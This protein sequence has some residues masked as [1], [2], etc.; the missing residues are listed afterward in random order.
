M[1]TN[2]TIKPE[3]HRGWLVCL[4]GGLAIFT[5][6]G[7]GM[8]I[9][10]TY[11]PY[12][13]QLNG[14]TNAQ[15]SLITTVRSFFAILA[16]LITSRLVQKIGLRATMGFGMGC[17]VLAYVVF[18]FA[19]SF[20]A[21]CV[22]GALSGLSYA[23][24][25]MV[26][27]SFAIARWFDVRR[28][29]ALGLAAAGSGVATIVAPTFVARSLQAQGLSATFFWEAAIMVV[30]MILVLA[31]VRNSP[32][33]LGLTPYGHGAVQSSTNHRAQRAPLSPTHWWLMLAVSFLAGAPVGAGFAHV[34]V[35]YSSQGF[36]SDQIT[37][38]FSYLGIVLMIGK[39][40]YGQISDV[41]GGY[42]SNYLIFGI[43]ILGM[44]LC[45]LSP[46]GSMAVA[47][48]A[49]TGVALSLSLS[50]I[51]QSIWMHELAPATQYESRVRL[52]NVAFMLGNLSF[53]ATPG[54]IADVT[55]SYIPAFALFG[56][57]TVIALLL[58]QIVYR[59]IG[60]PNQ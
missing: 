8:N 59:R 17:S 10:S 30:L 54:I 16:M 52:L 34:T 28:G 33:E 57:L 32:Q 60:I 47:F 49:M 21:Y 1:N 6:M 18:G 46:T 35:L 53:S 58:I 42:R 13:I 48:L 25:G 56:G 27:L 14:F 43:T 36:S 23:L 20:P 15:G 2:A 41:L 26:P 44:A 22:G 45:C 11:Q 9:Y 39:I 12:I 5:S 38:L 3:L 31:L 7:L 37:L 51:T 55:G 29:F 24:A 50:S 4:G 19:T 40:I